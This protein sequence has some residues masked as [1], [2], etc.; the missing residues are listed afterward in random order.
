MLSLP[1]NFSKTFETNNNNLTDQSKFPMT[2]QLDLIQNTKT[3]T[4]PR[5]LK[6]NIKP[7]EFRVQPNGYASLP[8]RR[9]NRRSYQM[10]NA[11]TEKTNP[12]ILNK[13]R[14]QTP[15]T[16]DEESPVSR[17]GTSASVPLQLE[18]LNT[19]TIVKYSNS[20]TS[21]PDI[22]NDKV[23]SGVV[24]N[25]ESMPDLALTTITR[26]SSVSDSDITS[27]QSGW[28]SSRRSSISS[29]SGQITPK[30]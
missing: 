6:E 18:A 26:F 3:M 29:L 9:N 16:S 13:N 4:L 5:R 15:P 23:I 30:G 25:S 27:E 11:V 1:L 17:L 7:P 20:T 8:L 10:T 12:I 19:S 2:K 14:S 28:V 21:I 24:N 22:V